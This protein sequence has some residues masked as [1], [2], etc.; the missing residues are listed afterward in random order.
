M[1][2]KQSRTPKARIV[3]AAQL[4]ITRRTN[5]LKKLEQLDDHLL[6]FAIRALGSPTN[7]AEWLITRAGGRKSPVPVDAALTPAGRTA[8]IVTLDHIKR[9]VLALFPE[10][11][12]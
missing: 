7:A 9:N 11:A 2:Q 12:S 4:E 6:S 1:K 3:V 5:C 10:K 8:V